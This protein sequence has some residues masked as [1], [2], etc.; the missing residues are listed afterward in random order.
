VDDRSAEGLPAGEQVG[1]GLARDERVPD[2]CWAA[3]R[4]VCRCAPVVPVD[5]SLEDG[6]PRADS[7]GCSLA[8]SLGFSIPGDCLV[9]RAPA[10]W[11]LSQAGGLSPD[12]CSVAQLVDDLPE[13][14]HSVPAAGSGGSRPADCSADSAGSQA[15][16]RDDSCR[17]GCLASADSAPW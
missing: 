6:S 9:E 7:A 17:D 4:P 8:V 15:V 5:D 13:N 12:G 11:A 10:G 14:D 2:D 1:C 3:Q 16:S